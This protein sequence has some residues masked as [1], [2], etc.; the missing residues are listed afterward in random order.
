LAFKHLDLNCHLDFDIWVLVYGIAAHLSGAR[1]D[2]PT[3][4]LRG[5]IVPKQSW[6]G[7][8]GI[9]APRQ[10]GARN[11]SPTLSLRGAIVPK[12][13]RWGWV[14]A[15]KSGQDFITITNG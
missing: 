12:Q 9:A 10:A 3:L 15:H 1:N 7:T 14:P 13:S 8:I 6:W 4:S 5:T 11:D 2:T